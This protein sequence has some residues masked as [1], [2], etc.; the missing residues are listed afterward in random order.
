MSV[1][2]SST[3]SYLPWVSG[4]SLS[5]ERLNAHQSGITVIIA[6][7]GGGGSASASLPVSPCMGTVLSNG[8]DTSPCVLQLYNP[9][10]S[11]KSLLVYELY[12]HSANG[13]K[14][15]VRRNSGSTMT[16]GSGATIFTPTLIHLDESDTTTIKASMRGFDFTTSSLFTETGSHW[17]G[18]LAIEGNDGW[19]PTAIRMAGNFP[20][21]LATGHA[22][23]IISANTGSTNTVTMTAVWD[24]L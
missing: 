4:E 2:T 23:E 8:S 15:F 20:W 18:D 3:I 7:C 19:Q 22:L 24:E 5:P 9:V 17:W 13:A 1:C 12:V 21:S 16:S 6:N 11:G 10:S 14:I